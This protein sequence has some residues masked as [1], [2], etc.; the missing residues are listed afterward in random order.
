MKKS[1]IWL[2]CV[3][4]F[5]LMVNIQGE[6]EQPVTQLTEDLKKVIRPKTKDLLT[7]EDFLK[8]SGTPPSPQEVVDMKIEEE[9]VPSM[10]ST[11]KGAAEVQEQKP[12]E[13]EAEEIIEEEVEPTAQVP[14]KEEATLKEPVEA[15]HTHT[16]QAKED[17]DVE[18]GFLK[19]SQSSSPEVLPVVST[20]N[21]KFDTEKKRK[22]V[23]TL[24]DRA[25]HELQIQPLD[26]ACNRF[27]HTKEF[28]HGDLY[29]FVYDTNGVCLAHGDDAYLLWQNK[30]D[31]TDWVGTPI[32]KQIIKKAQAGG[33][34]VTYG[35]NNST[36]VAYVRLVEKEGKA[37]V[38]GSGFFPHSKEEAVVNL[39]KGG[40]ALFNQVKKDK[41]PTYWAFSRMSY[42]SGSFV[43]GNLYLYALDFK[44]NILAQGERPGLINTNSWDYQDEKGLYVNREIVKKLET[45]PDG[46]WIEYI[47]KRARKKAYAEKVIDN[48]GNKYFI[49]C[50]YY[51]EGN[52][53]ATVDLV[54]KG[55]QFMKTS[56]KTS[57]VQAFSQRSS[58]EYRYGD[59]YL[60]VYD[61]KGKIIADGGNADNIGRDM[62][63]EMDQDGFP[64]IQRMIKR[65]TKEGIWSNAKIQGSFQSTY[66][67]KIDLGVS[68][69]VITCSYYPVS[70]PETMMLLVQS[71]LSFLKANPREDAFAQFVKREGSFR[72]GDLQ[73]V[74]VDTT[75]LCYA[76][77]DDVDLIWRNIFDVKDDT[78]RPFIKMFINDVRQGPTVIKTKLNGAVKINYVTSLEKGG[79]TYVISSGYYE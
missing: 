66:A 78:G 32:V 4:I 38:V 64:Y 20:D 30:I 37:Y 70:K 14:V 63:H 24:V 7:A 61:M 26:I 23:M 52:R 75:G 57:A 19:G 59:L 22:E 6:P 2:V 72:R 53:Q 56:G 65:A 40:V 62:S 51:P 76:Y 27:T 9:S 17:D 33:G 73:L 74:V 42:P 34:W 11:V 8:E 18:E 36:K 31:L 69:F 48:K 13:I 1:L 28:I 35:W 47:S 15:L 68:Q 5:S 58:D 39:V 71:G 49:A 79:K 77:G 10:L 55:Y 50:G 41:Q 45:S 21:L 60:V 3:S 25:V 16:Q 44:G 46:V 43:A 54:R 12:E 67:Q 29:I